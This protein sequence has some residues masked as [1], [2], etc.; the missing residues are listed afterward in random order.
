[1]TEQIIKAYVLED[2]K[3]GDVVAII[4]GKAV[5]VGSETHKALENPQ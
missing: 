5:V 3:E 1:M 4:D 2:I